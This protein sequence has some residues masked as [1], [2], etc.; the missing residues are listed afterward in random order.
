MEK[1]GFD[2]ARLDKI[3]LS[4][5]K[6]SGNLYLPEIHTNLTLSEL[7]KLPVNGSR[8]IA[9]CMTT[10]KDLLKYRYKKDSDVLILIG[11]EGDFSDREI[12][13]AL[14]QGF[15]PVNLGPL[16]LRSETAAFA[17]A[18]SIHILNQ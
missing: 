17:A 3:A 14:L 7:C 5:L 1:K 9:H 12:D 18:L 11:P 8:F 6:Q 4:A 16:R 10:E 13:N 2:K 15:I